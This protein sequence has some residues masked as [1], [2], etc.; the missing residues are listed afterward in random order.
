MQTYSKFRPTGF[1]CAGLALDDH[2]DWLVAP[3]STNRDADCLTRSN[4][5]VVTS[6]IGE[7]DD[8]EIH[9]FGHWACGW[10]EIMIVR[11]GSDAARK[12]EEWEGALSD[13]PVASDDHFSD[14]EYTEVQEYWA[15]MP[16]DERRRE[17]ERSGVSKLVAYRG[18]NLPDRLW[19]RLR[20]S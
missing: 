17:C 7:G 2:Q 12:A 20:D 5:Y 10:F 14:L 8:A 16:L 4:W 9:R 19:E 15:R 6:D 13:Y 18:N 11:P 1:D 3:V